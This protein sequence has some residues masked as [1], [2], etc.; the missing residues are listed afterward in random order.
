MSAMTFSMTLVTYGS[1]SPPKQ[2]ALLHVA[3]HKLYKNSIHN[4]IWYNINRYSKSCTGLDRLWGFQEGETP[5]FQ[6]NQPYAMATVI[7]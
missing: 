1:I 4:L 2:E 5:R 7:S 3:M 6:D